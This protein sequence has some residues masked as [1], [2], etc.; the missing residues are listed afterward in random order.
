MPNAASASDQIE[1]IVVM[2]F[3]NRSFDQIFGDCPGVNGLFDPKHAFKHECY[4]V[5]DPLKEPGPG[6]ERILPRAL[7]VDK[8][9]DG[10]P[11][12]SF[13]GMIVDIFGPGTTGVL[14]GKPINNPTKTH[15]DGMS[16]FV[17]HNPKD[18]QRDYIMGYFEC[19]KLKVL[20]TLAANFLVCDNWFCDLPGHTW[21]NRM[22]MHCA[23]TFNEEIDDPNAGHDRYW[24][25]YQLLEEAHLRG[26]VASAP[27]KMYVL[28]GS[29]KGR[30]QYGMA[31]S[32]FLNSY[33]RTSPCTNRPISEFVTDVNNG[34]LPFYSFIVPGPPQSCNQPWMNT[35]MH[36]VAMMQPGENVLGAVYN[37]LR[38]SSYWEK[39][40]LIVTFDENGG[41]YDHVAPLEAAIPIPQFKPSAEDKGQREFDFSLLGPRIPVLLIS[42]W[43]N[44]GVDSHQYQNTS[45]LRF[46]EEKAGT[47]ARSGLTERD[48]KA[49]SLSPAFQ[50]FGTDAP[51]TK[52]PEKLELYVDVPGQTGKKFP[53]YDGDLMCPIDLVADCSDST[54]KPTM[55][56]FTLDYVRFL[57]GHPDSGKKITREFATSG[58]L[59]RYVRERV[60][61]AESFDRGDRSRAHR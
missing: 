11:D 26:G 27:W 1:N 24:T 4:N 19:G 60:Q 52:T 41:L 39:T 36:P 46:L 55:L 6:N 40:L 51:R 50:D 12:H 9:L 13:P 16:G 61:A 28:A 5:K 25:I 44:Q 59:D 45:I 23:T 15:P 56:D 58:D 32:Y 3:E 17:Y 7:D 48:Y 38:S 42:P 53:Y 8:P 10:D 21:P 43:L 2:M 30:L 35:S 14:H 34:T 31:D 22:F 37:T 47:F 33:V 54:G 20:H 57:P 18:E 49:N 29:E